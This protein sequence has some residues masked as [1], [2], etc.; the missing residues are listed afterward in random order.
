MK[1]Y[2]IQRARTNGL[3]S[4]KKFMSKRKLKDALSNQR[5]PTIIVRMPSTT[6]LKALTRISSSTRRYRKVPMPLR[7]IRLIKMNRIS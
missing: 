4:K 2:Y 3:M 6:T 1:S 5:P 7:I